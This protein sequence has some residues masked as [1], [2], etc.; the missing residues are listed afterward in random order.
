MG[1]KINEWEQALLVDGRGEADGDEG[2]GVR[3]PKK[4]SP[5]LPSSSIELEQPS[6]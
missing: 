3:E 5:D 2:D 1:V 4:P 6:R